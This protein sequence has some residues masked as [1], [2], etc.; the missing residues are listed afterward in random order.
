MRSTATETTNWNTESMDSTGIETPFT[1]IPCFKTSQ[2]HDQRSGNRVPEN[3]NATEAQALIH[4]AGQLLAAE[5]GE[6]RP[7]VVNSR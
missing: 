5:S 3:S 2:P 6:F 4:R 1:P 7:L